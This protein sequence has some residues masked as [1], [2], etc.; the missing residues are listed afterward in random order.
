MDISVLLASGAVAAVITG[1][2]IFIN[3]RFQKRMDFNYS[4]R[5]FILDKRKEAYKEVENMLKWFEMDRVLVNMGINTMQKEYEVV[6]KNALACIHT[7]KPV[8][9]DDIW[10]SEHIYDTIVKFELTLVAVHASTSIS[11]NYNHEGVMKAID[12]CIQKYSD[13]VEAYFNDIIKLDQIENF[14]KEKVKQYRKRDMLETIR[15]FASV[16]REGT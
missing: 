6:H 3:N 5:T 7:I 12:V 13:V 15:R 14:T 4:Y 10:R 1:T 2:W 11:D 8:S 9:K 16:W